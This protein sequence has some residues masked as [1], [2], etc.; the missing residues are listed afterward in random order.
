MKKRTLSLY[1]Y[2]REQGRHGPAKF[3]WFQSGS[4]VFN[5][6]VRCSGASYC[7]HTQQWSWNHVNDFCFVPNL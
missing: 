1:I 3:L 4:G 7:S 2:R 6:L 5:I